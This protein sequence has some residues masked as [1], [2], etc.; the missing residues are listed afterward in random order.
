MFHAALAKP[1]TSF[2]VFS[3]ANISQSLPVDRVFV[4]DPTLYIDDNLTLAWYAGSHVQPDLQD[5]IAQILM[6]LT[7]HSSQTIAF[8]ASGGGFAALY[9]ASRLPSA[10]AIPVNPQVDLARYS[11]GPVRKWLRLGWNS[12]ADIGGL[13]EIPT[14]TDSGLAYRS[15]TPAK[16]WYV[17]NT[18]DQN[19]MKNHYGPFMKSLPWGHN[20]VPILVDAGAGHVPPQK[21]HLQNILR[22]ASEGHTDPPSSEE[23]DI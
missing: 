13:E 20:V 9:Y 8:G 12:D 6:E 15:G 1:G 17:Q 4:A 14:V 22:A 23:L 2:P 3:G 10:L 19:H 18:G 7:S 5:A 11:P 21:R 16:V